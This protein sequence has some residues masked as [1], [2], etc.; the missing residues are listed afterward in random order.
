MHEGGTEAFILQVADGDGKRRGFVGRVRLDALGEIVAQDG[1]AADDAE[2]AACFDDAGGVLGGEDLT[3]GAEPH[4]PMREP[5]P[6]TT[7]T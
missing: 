7:R 4:I 2:V 1:G 5:A 3:G 6:D